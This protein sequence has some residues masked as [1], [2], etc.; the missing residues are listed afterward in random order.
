MIKIAIFN[1]GR[2]VYTAM[3]INQEYPLSTVIRAPRGASKSEVERICIQR[4][5]SQRMEWKKLGAPLP[6]LSKK[7]AWKMIWFTPSV[8]WNNQPKLNIPENVIKTAEMELVK[9][10]GL[11]I[12][13]R[14]PVTQ[15]REKMVMAECTLDGKFSFTPLTE[16]IIAVSEIPDYIASHTKRD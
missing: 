16:D 10:P 4:F 5:H 11:T 12:T 1:Q 3:S 2:D 7:N 8:L 6:N 9:E 14:V 13:K 15:E